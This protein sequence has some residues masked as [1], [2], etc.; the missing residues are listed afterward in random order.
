MK[1]VLVLGGGFG[2]VQAA[3]ELQKKGIF[4]VTLVSDRDYLYLY[5]ISIWIPTG[6]IPFE[7]V[8][9]PLEEVRKANNFNLVI[10]TV[11]SIQSFENKVYCKNGTLEY[12]YLVLALGADKMKHQG[13]EHTL[14]ICGN[15]EMS[16]EIREQLNKLINIGTGRIAI[17]FGGNPKDKSAVRGGPAFELLFNI[18]ELL[19]EKGIRKN[20][21]LHFFAPME[22]PGEKM[23]KQSVAMVDAMF[24]SYNVQKHYGKKIKLFEQKSIVFEDDSKQQADLIVFIPASS[25]HSVLKNSDLQLSDAGFIK[26]DDSCKVEGLNNVY[27]IG[28]IASLNGPAW[29]AK[30]GHIAELMARNTAQNIF[31]FEKGIDKRKGYEEHLNILCVMDTGRGA[32]IVFRNEK[33][34]FV[35]PLPI[36]G[37]WLK[38]GWG[39][40]SKLTKK[41][42]FPRLPGL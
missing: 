8:K 21:E 3:I 22:Q 32:A 25:S 31:N 30:Q 16:V 29:K 40:Y 6:K 28:D 27:A 39:Y 5:P 11:E 26:T 14:S 4:E 33:K 38:Q 34:A 10:D 24:T 12:D 41:R 37:H 13:I 7:K 18:H 9:L 35:L 2:G 20:F 15:P 1:K 42:L 17:G 36:V 19:K 23:G